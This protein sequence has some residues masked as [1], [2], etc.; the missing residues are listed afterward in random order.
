MQY[1][2]AGYN[3]EAK[4]GRD[5]AMKYCHAWQREIMRASS[6]LIADLSS[7]KIN[8]ATYNLKRAE[9]NKQTE[10]LNDCIAAVNRQTKGL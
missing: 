4:R 9:L 7:K 2:T 1:S 8:Q 5:E 10:S 6:N 3:K